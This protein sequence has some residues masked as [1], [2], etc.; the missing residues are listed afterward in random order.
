M[1]NNR[2][3]ELEGTSNFREIGGLKTS[4]GSKLKPGILFRSDELFKLTDNDLSTI[5]TLNLKLIIDL[6]T[7]N[8]CKLKPDRLPLNLS[9]KVVNVPFFHQK[10]DYNQLQIMWFLIT[11]S[12]KINFEKFIKDHY[13]NNAFERTAEIGKVITLLSD[14][15]NLPVLIHCKAGK[16]RTGLLSAIIQLIAGV[17]LNIVLEDY[18]ATN[19]Y[20]KRKMEDA[21]KII[22]RMSF[23]RVSSERIK[24]LLEVRLDYLNSVLN[25]IFSRYGTIEKYLIEACN[26]EEY[27][28]QNL[29]NNLV[30]KS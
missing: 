18:L 4:N 12:R 29:K 13:L 9:L 28:L 2:F 7:P 11:N 6:R 21:E 15:N 16:D 22:R 19:M 5:E 1:S 23:F 10:R 20:M 14:E 3:I 30:E 8:E 25:E 27:S 17:P 26:L 24:P